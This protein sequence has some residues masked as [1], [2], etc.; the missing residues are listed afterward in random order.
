MTNLETFKKRADNVFK[1][2][3]EFDND[4][5]EMKLKKMSE[6]INKLAL[7][8]VHVSKSTIES[9][10]IPETTPKKQTLNNKTSE[11]GNIR[12]TVTSNNIT[13][14]NT[15]DTENTKTTGNCSN[16]TKQN[17]IDE[18]QETPHRAYASLF[19][20][21][22]NRNSEIETSLHSNVST[23]KDVTKKSPEVIS[24][25]LTL[26]DNNQ[27]PQMFDNPKPQRKLN[28][29]KTERHQ[30]K[31]QTDNKT[32][33]DNNTNNNESEFR[34]VYREKK[35]RLFVDNIHKTSTFHGFLEFLK[36][37]KN[38]HPSGL[39]LFKSKRS[40]HQAAKVHLYPEEAD[41]A[42]SDGF[43]PRGV[44]C[45]LW[46]TREE[47]TK[48]NSENQKL[49]HDTFKGC[50]TDDESQQ[51]YNNT[52]R[53]KKTKTSRRSR[54]RNNTNYKTNNEYDDDGYSNDSYNQYEQENNYN[55]Y[56]N[57]NW[58]KNNYR[59]SDW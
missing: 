38:L 42:L 58:N 47:V 7:K 26:T 54:Y 46:L 39:N 12:D 10:D 35:K 37:T 32:R 22:P 43:W 2:I 9:S 8:S 6:S 48:R 52:N 49:N 59:N 21:L 44:T 41:Q 30:N 3:G 33:E 55:S 27:Y 20:N 45:D 50:D 51:D 25:D 23:H 4:L 40:G 53:N 5:N 16:G 28:D 24:I 15:S 19:H 14:H 17:K 31:H 11:H 29:K 57:T 1:N 34:G 13:K 18:T 36:T 56:G